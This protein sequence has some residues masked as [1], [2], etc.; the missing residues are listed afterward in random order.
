MFA[1][2]FAGW[3]W[4]KVARGTGNADPKTSF[5]T[6]GAAGLAAFIV[7]FTLMKYVLHIGS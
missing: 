5:L 1:A 3:I 6:A 7:L 2:G 4:T